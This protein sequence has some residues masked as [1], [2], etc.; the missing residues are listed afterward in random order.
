M[1]S[2]A[3]KVHVKATAGQLL[4]AGVLLPEAACAA[5]LDLPAIFE[6]SHPVEVEVGSGKG[7]FLLG[8]AAARPD[9]SLLGLEWVRSHALYAADRARRA[10]LSN[11]RLLCADARDV[12]ENSLPQCSVLR[13]HIY[14]PD[15][16]PKRRH[17]ARRLLVPSFLGCACRVLQPG[18]WLGILT[19]HAGYFRQIAAAMESISS[20]AR[21]S[22]RPPCADGTWLVGSN[23]E[24][25][26]VAAGRELY[27]LAGIRYL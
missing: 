23:F 16:W 21:I 1:R 2:R 27:G 17:R 10:G 22:F 25:K 14:F 18:G 19:D 5:K 12:F 8:R 3:G 9:L 13:I 20:F 6:N 15:P 26:Y 7:G 4:S 11:V 24:K